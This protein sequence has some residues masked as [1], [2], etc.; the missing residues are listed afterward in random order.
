MIWIKGL[1]VAMLV[2]PL[3]YS[4][5]SQPEGSIPG[6]RFYRM[7]ESEYVENRHVEVW[8]P[9]GYHAD[10]SYDV[11]YMHD[12]QNVFNPE[13]S[14][15]GTAWE[16]DSSMIG[17]MNQGKIRPAIVVAIWNTPMRIQEYMPGKP[18]GKL[19]KELEKDGWDSGVFSDNYLK[20]IVQEL[21]PFI[22]K[23]YATRPE[24]EHTFIMG[25]SMGGLIS[26]YALMEYP[27]VFGGA[28][29]ISSH[30]PAL[31]GVF[32]QHVE[33]GLPKPGNHKLYFD[34]GTET[35]DA[36]YEPF[37]QRVDAAIER[38]GYTHGQHW[39]TLKFDGTDHSEKAW[40]DRVHIPLEFLLG[41]E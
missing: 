29:C 14:Y 35:L 6:V 11:L 5:E 41:V 12:G 15:S 17:L 4:C 9:P 3:L 24:R 38:R 8:L 39:L 13:T 28:A 33:P 32:V 16:V 22:D 10:G 31:R 23:N 40:R 2:L 21:K 27:D 19:K 36:E 1:I 37:Q 18:E 26:L 7:F 25:S 30:W 34:Y 20:F